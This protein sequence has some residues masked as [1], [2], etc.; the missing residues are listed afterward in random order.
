MEDL[1][2]LE[3]APAAGR[4]ERQSRMTE[5][6]N[7]LVS[8]AFAKFG[9]L[10][11]VRLKTETPAKESQHVILETVSHL[12][13]VSALVQFKSVRDSIRVE[14]VMQFACIHSQTV[15]IADIDGDAAV[16]TQIDD[17]LVDESQR[18]ISRPFREDILLCHAVLC[19]QVK[20]KRRFFRIG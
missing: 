11:A 4:S 19:R 7:C 1:T 5:K 17:V 20:V 8:T 16:C 9:R 10:W 12:T 6:R 2:L 18:R 13:R 14:S 3:A 15:L